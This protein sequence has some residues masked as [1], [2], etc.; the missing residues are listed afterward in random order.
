M[1]KF[2]KSNYLFN[3]IN[4]LKDIWHYLDSDEALAK[5]KIMSDEGRPALLG[6]LRDIEE[7]FHNDEVN[8][9]EINNYEE[10]HQKKIKLQIN[11]QI[12]LMI[13]QVMFRNSY[14]LVKSDINISFSGSKYFKNASLYST[15]NYMQNVMNDFENNLKNFNDSLDY[16]TVSYETYTDHIILLY[17][18][19]FL[20][21]AGS[22]KK[23]LSRRFFKHIT[24]IL[25]DLERKLKEIN[26][27]TYDNSNIMFL[28]I[29]G[30]LTIN[31]LEYNSKNKR[32][33]ETFNFNALLSLTSHGLSHLFMG[34]DAYYIKDCIKLTVDKIIN[35]GFINEDEIKIYITPIVNRINNVQ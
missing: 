5:M 27:E 30:V 21:L 33:L 34:K 18:S 8:D 29:L 4:V 32:E 12:G 9:N 28:G 25:Y 20:E 31:L 13:S 23:N 16:K 22:Y 2:E 6:V 10:Q 1:T 19:T 24:E 35:T 3:E 11:Q 14:L 7:M 17:K 15:E 26:K